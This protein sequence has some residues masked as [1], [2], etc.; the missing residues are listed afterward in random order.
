MAYLLNS[1]I[2]ILIASISVFFKQVSTCIQAQSCEDLK[3]RFDAY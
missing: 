3:S 2:Y 1:S